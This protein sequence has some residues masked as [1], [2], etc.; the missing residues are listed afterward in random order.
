VVT[1][2]AEAVGVGGNTIA[3]VET[4]NN[5]SWAWGADALM[6]GTDEVLYDQGKQVAVTPQGFTDGEMAQARENIEAIGED[7]RNQPDGFAG[8]DPSGNY[9]PVAVVA[10]RVD[11][12]ESDVTA[13]DLRVDAV[14][15][16]QASDRIAYQTLALLNADLVPA[17]NAL[18]EVTNDDVDAVANNGTYIKVGATGTGSW[19]KSTNDLS[20]RV[21]NN[22][23]GLSSVSA[24]LIGIAD[25]KN[26]IDIS[27][28]NF[29]KRYSNSSKKLQTDTIGIAASDWISVV[30]GETYTVSGLGFYSGKNGGYFTAHGASTAVENITYGSSDTGGGQKFTVPTGQNITHVIVSLKK[31][32]GDPAKTTLKGDVQL[33]LGSDA[34]EY[35]PYGYW[36]KNSSIRNLPVS[37]VLGA[38]P[39]D[40]EAW[41]KF[42]E[43]AESVSMVDRLPRFREKWFKRQSD[44]MVVNV[45]TS[46]TARTTEHCTNHKEAS[47]RPPLFHSNN[48]ASLIW[49]KIKWDNQFYKRYDSGFFAES[50]SWATNHNLGE[51]DDGAYRNGL[52]R[53]SGDASASVSFVIPI[54]AWQFNFIYRTDSVGC[55][56]SVVVDEGNGKIEVHDGAAWVEANGYSLSQNEPAPVPRSISVPKASTGTVVSRTIPSKGNTT[57]QKRL[58][59]RCRSGAIDSRAEQKNVTITRAGGG[60]RMMYW[61]VEWSNREFMIT[62]VN[63][64]RGSHNTQARGSTGLPRFADNEVWGFKPDLMLFELPIHNDGAGGANAY[65]AQYWQRL[66]DDYVFDSSY[67]LSMETRA[68][69]FGLDPEIAM[70]T[71]SITWN[72]GGI[73]DD[74]S[75]KLGN[76]NDGNMMTAFD[77]YNEAVEWV[78]SNHPSVPIINATD[79]WIRAGVAIHGDL[80]SATI[81]SGKDGKTFTNEG[82]HWND[83]GS[84]IMAKVVWPLINFTS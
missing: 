82:G 64:A 62:Y 51:W 58:K 5:G 49:D 31:T 22:E 32:D 55:N 74:G 59:M 30:E 46:L 21:T 52:T 56:A 10:A 66:T 83:T 14:E 38:V 7:Q 81:A 63:A 70:F 61:G 13:T 11:A 57:Y 20:G 16:A 28:I 15:L 34:S 2:S 73:N 76:Q 72:F 50:G 84:R 19:L 45:G 47:S 17:D 36:I 37:S 6:W 44:L 67:E 53:Y 65:A 8:L 33:E 41:Y 27:S 60:T 80:K 39:F 78:R 24:T 26:K 54:D 40:P 43:G 18:G 23:V 77:K 79:R 69:F 3:T 29:V 75:L 25:S 1:V 9:P 68:A 35:V 42:V 71:S 4:L 48:F 12:V